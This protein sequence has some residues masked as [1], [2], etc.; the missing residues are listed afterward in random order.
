MEKLEQEQNKLE[1][2]CQVIKDQVRSKP[3]P[4]LIKS[5]THQSFPL[6]LLS[7][8]LQYAR[9][10]IYFP[11]QITTCL[12]TSTTVCQNIIYPLP[13]P[14]QIGYPRLKLIRKKTIPHL[15]KIHL[16]DPTHQPDFCLLELLLATR[17]LINGQNIIKTQACSMFNRVI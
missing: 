2:L 3:I 13:P 16:I 14:S 7:T 15:E 9:L 4:K 6:F 12:T 10:F 8:C 11:A 17:S 1:F 5:Y